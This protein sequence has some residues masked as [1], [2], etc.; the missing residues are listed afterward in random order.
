[1]PFFAGSG[2]SVLTLLLLLALILDNNIEPGIEGLGDDV[3]I[4]KESLDSLVPI[5]HLAPI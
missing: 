4:S 2:L 3:G 1:M 5:L